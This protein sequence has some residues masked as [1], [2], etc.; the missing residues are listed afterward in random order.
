MNNREITKIKNRY[1]L[2]SKWLLNLYIVKKNFEEKIDINIID[3]IISNCLLSLEEK[4]IS[5]EF[6]YYRTGIC[7]L[8]FGAR[9][10]E[11]TIWHFGK[12]GKT[13]EYFCCTWYCYNRNYLEMEL[14][15][16][17]EPHFSQYEAELIAECLISIN[18]LLIKTKNVSEFRN[19]FYI[20]DEL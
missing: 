8:H 7:F 3:I 15:D 1:F 4:C 16:N 5:D 12:W 20:S 9:G 2:D 6:T 17:A 18:K 10:V 14:L 13:K 11:F 19:E